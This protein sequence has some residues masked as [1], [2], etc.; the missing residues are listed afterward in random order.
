MG[1][2]DPT[3]KMS[4]S[5]ES[6]YN[7]I[8]FSDSPESIQKKIAKAVTDSGSEIVYS[9]EKPAIKNLINIYSL[10]SDKSTAEIEKMYKN[11]NYAEFKKDLA[12][13]MVNFLTPFQKRL[14]NLDDKHVKDILEK[15]AERAKK[16][17]QSKIT[18]VKEKVGLI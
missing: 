4:K 7:F 6:I 8:A 9:D 10:L 17:A 15:G 1:L 2:D 14:A 11:K 5:A 18:E 12:E 16:I 13:V 3:K